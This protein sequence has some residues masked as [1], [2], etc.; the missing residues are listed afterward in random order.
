MNELE[1][2]Q[3]ARIEKLEKA[4][5]ALIGYLWR[6]QI[7]SEDASEQLGELLKGEQ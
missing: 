3:A 7:I 2:I 5:V 6:H 1:T 4:L